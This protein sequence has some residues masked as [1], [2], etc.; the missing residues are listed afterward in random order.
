MPLTAAVFILE[1]TYAPAALLMP[2]CTGMTGALGTS[3]KMGF[4]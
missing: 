3:G 1:L 2:L 4:K